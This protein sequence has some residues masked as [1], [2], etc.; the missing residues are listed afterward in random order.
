M[1]EWERDSKKERKK[2]SKAKYHNWLFLFGNFKPQL[3]LIHE[4][5]WLDFSKRNKEKKKK[6]KKERKKKKENKRR[7]REKRKKEFLCSHIWK[8]QSCVTLHKSS[9][10]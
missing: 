4:M 7:M 8:G 5:N 2:T 6:K 1:L 3:F 10:C 9:W